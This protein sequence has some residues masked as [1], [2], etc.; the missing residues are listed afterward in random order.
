MSIPCVK[1]PRSMF[2]FSIMLMVTLL[3]VLAPRGVFAD[4][5]V[6][7]NGDTTLLGVTAATAPAVA[8]ASESPSGGK[9]WYQPI[10]DFFDGLLA[11]QPKQAE[12]PAPPAP[13]PPDYTNMSAAEAQLRVSQISY[14]DEKGIFLKEYVKQNRARLTALDVV[15]LVRDQGMWTDDKD[16][17]LVDYSLA[18]PELSAGDRSL[19]AEECGWNESRDRVLR[20]S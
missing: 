2:R 11:P 8:S 12:K 17:I 15:N 18:H 13:P 9:P 20:G 4:N 16:Q 10:L 19:L 3:V 1:E 14:T 5:P 7:A 6:C